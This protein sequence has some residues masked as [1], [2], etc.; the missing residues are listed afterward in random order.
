MSDIHSRTFHLGSCKVG[1][2]DK[3]GQTVLDA[4]LGGGLTHFAVCIKLVFKQKFR[5]NYA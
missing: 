1:R 3:L 5:P 2:V 4:G